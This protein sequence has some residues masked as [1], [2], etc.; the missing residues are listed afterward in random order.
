MWVATTGATT[1]APTGATTGTSGS[2]PVNSVLAV[3]DQMDCD[4]GADVIVGVL[5]NDTA[6]GQID[7]NSLFIV[8]LPTAGTASVSA[9]SIGY[10]HDGSQTLVDTFTYTVS[11]FDGNVSNVATVTINAIDQP[12]TA[13]DD[14]EVT[15]PGAMANFDLASNDVDP[16]GELDLASIVV[17]TLPAN[18]TLVVQADGTVDYTHDGGASTVDSFDYTIADLVGNVSNTAF[19]DVTISTAIPY[20]LTPTTGSF[21]NSTD[22]PWWANKGYEFT[23]LA[24]FSITGGA[25]FID[26]PNGGFVRL[27]VYDVAGN[28]LA[29]GTQSFGNGTE[30]WHQS[31]LVYNF[32]V[33][34]TYTV[35]FY[36]DLAASSIFDRMDGPVYGYDVAGVVGNITHRSS[37]ASGDGANEEWPDYFGNTWAPFQRLDIVP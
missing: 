29:R 35:S 15:A 10:R 33:G 25:W 32:Y 31:D 19:V 7:N 16:E 27:S 30:M 22:D 26:V 8:D 13:I 12:P 23:A 11:D 9:G 18:G 28:L 17:G 37:N 6:T 21:M 3:D 36:T 24:D 4:R 14:I 1:G 5:A 34:Q 20:E 2:T